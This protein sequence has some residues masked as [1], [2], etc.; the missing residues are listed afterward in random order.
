M[1]S[2]ASANVPR[3]LKDKCPVCFDHM[4]E[5]RIH[6]LPI[7]D[8]FNM[9]V[10]PYGPLATFLPCGHKLHTSCVLQNEEQFHRCAICRR[11]IPFPCLDTYHIGIEFSCQ[12]SPR[13]R[14]VF[15]RVIAIHVPSRRLVLRSFGFGPMSATDRDKFMLYPAKMSRTQLSRSQWFAFVKTCWL[16]VLC[17]RTP[18][19]VLVP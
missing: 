13:R 11:L 19:F 2:A 10:Y 14:V 7:G 5:Y 9:C 3:F 15:Y 12:L 4:A 18:F 17:T 6:I 16:Y 8:R 1:G